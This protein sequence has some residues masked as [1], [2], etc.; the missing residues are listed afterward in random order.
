LFFEKLWKASIDIKKFGGTEG[1]TSM[2]IKLGWNKREK[3]PFE[4]RDEGLES[5]LLRWSEMQS[6]GEEFKGFINTIKLA[7]ETIESQIKPVF[8]R[9]NVFICDVAFGIEPERNDY[10]LLGK[11]KLFALIK[12][13]ELPGRGLFLDIGESG[14]NFKNCFI[15][16][17][18]RKYSHEETSTITADSIEQ[19]ASDL[20]RE[21]IPKEWKKSIGEI[22]RV[23]KRLRVMGDHDLSSWYTS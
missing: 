1:G 22:T 20:A 2:L 15:L 17:P 21:G 14:F 12:L 8:K 10:K 23:I 18:S 5:F 19:I 16:S 9:E 7:L 6:K 11:I 13:T 4:L 3:L